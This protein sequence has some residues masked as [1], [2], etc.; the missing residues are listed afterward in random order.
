MDGLLFHPILFK[1]VVVTLMPK[2]NEKMIA[3]CN[4]IDHG[5]NSVPIK[6]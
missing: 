5:L 1:Y 4:K 6:Y 2:M 3:A